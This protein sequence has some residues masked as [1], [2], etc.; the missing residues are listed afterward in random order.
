MKCMKRWFVRHWTL[1]NARQCSLREE[2]QMM[3]AL[4][5]LQL[6]ALRGLLS[7]GTR[8][9]NQRGRLAGLLSWGDRAES[10]DQGGESLQA[11]RSEKELHS[12]RA[13]EILLEYS[14][15]NQSAYVCEGTTWSLGINHSEDQSEEYLVLTQRIVPVL[16]S[17]TRGPNNSQGL[18][19]ASGNSC[20]SSGK[21]LALDRALFWPHLANLENKTPKDQTV[22]KCFDCIQN[23]TQ[24]YL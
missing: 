16:A 19:R 18:S 24:E 14:A 9:G 22:S 3:R 11:G 6:T 4:W 23:E 8:R 20:L 1:R 10:Q 15:E 13:L 5:L 7:H 2:R 12:E 17:Q 21:W